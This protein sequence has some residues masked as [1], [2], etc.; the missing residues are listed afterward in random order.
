MAEAMDTTTTTPTMGGGID[1][2]AA[3]ELLRQHASAKASEVRPSN[4]RLGGQTIDLF[5]DNNDND[6]NN[7]SPKEEE[8]SSKMEEEEALKPLMVASLGEIINHVFEVQRER[9]EAYRSFDES[10][11]TAL[12]SAPHFYG[13]SVKAATKRFDLA[14]KRMKNC[15]SELRRRGAIAGADCI[16]ALQA[17]EKEHLELTAA[18]HLSAFRQDQPDSDDE[19]QAKL[20]IVID[21]VN[22]ALEN[23]RMETE[24]EE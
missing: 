6:N 12:E 9:V 10:L 16:S 17:A 15:E 23:L 2:L 5:G 22:D 7:N 19:L 11:A 1:P 13:A 24:G 18:V 14:S 21:K 8:R 4:V 3:C 20:S